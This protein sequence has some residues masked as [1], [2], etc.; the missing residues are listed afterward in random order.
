V[1]NQDDGRYQGIQNEYIGNSGGNGSSSNN[2]GSSSGGYSG[3]SGSS[4]SGIYPA[5]SE[6][7][8]TQIKEKNNEIF[9]LRPVEL[10]P[11]GEGWTVNYSNWPR[12]N[13]PPKDSHGGVDI[14]AP[15][16]TEIYSVYYGT[17]Y[18]IT[19][20]DKFGNIVGGGHYV[21]VESVI[22]DEIVKISYM[23]MSSWAIE[24]GAKVA[25]GDLIGYVGD[26]GSPK[27]GAYH[28][29]FQKNFN[30]KPGDDPRGYLP[31]EPIK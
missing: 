24:S 20:R 1:A 23:H 15:K 26:T 27:E 29:H 17:A 4:T 8:S 30:G 7:T 31:Q 10:W 14:A 22:N 2:T 16:G 28:L 6:L 13:D 11:L 19:Q 18:T 3:G 12:Y 9:Q 5:Y 25:P 21:Y